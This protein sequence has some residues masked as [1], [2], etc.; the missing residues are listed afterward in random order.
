MRYAIF[1][2]TLLHS[3]GASY[4]I[5]LSLKGKERK[6]SKFHSK[7]KLPRH[8]YTL[9]KTMHAYYLQDKKMNR[10]PNSF[11]KGLRSKPCCAPRE[12]PSILLG[13]EK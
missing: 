11:R 13:S 5:Q 1:F 7:N 6:G 3:L 12:K 2:S 10:T 8:E 4:K 9:Y